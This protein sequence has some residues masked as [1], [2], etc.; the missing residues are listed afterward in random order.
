MNSFLDFEKMK[1][2]W[3]DFEIMKSFL[4]FIKIIYPNFLFSAEKNIIGYL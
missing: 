3:I 1:D 4:K 2:G